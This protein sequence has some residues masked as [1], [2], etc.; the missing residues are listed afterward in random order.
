MTATNLKYEEFNPSITDRLKEQ[1][2]KN[3]QNNSIYSNFGKTNQVKANYEGHEYAFNAGPLL[4]DK[5]G[6]SDFDDYFG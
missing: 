5:G 6:Y 4:D 2:R 1:Q 3:S